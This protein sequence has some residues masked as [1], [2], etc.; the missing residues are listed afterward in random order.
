MTTS[1]TPLCSSVQCTVS[2]LDT[3]SSSLILWNTQSCFQWLQM[4]PDSVW[5]L[6]ERKEHNF[7]LDIEKITFS[8]TLQLAWHGCLLVQHSNSV[9]R[10]WPS[11]TAFRE[12]LWLCM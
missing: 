2:C 12:W 3:H 11:V 7:N 10:T 8:S 6:K 1:V 4:C 5:K 9:A